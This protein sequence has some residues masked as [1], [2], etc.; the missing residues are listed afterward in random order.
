M[1]SNHVLFVVN[2]QLTTAERVCVACLLELTELAKPVE[3]QCVTNAQ[4]TLAPSAQED[5]T[6]RQS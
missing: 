6:R 3:K 1:V 4:N 5:A 2:S